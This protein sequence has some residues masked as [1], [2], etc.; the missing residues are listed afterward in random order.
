M[1]NLRT[2]LSYSFYTLLVA[3][4][5]GCQGGTSG[6]STKKANNYYSDM[7]SNKKFSNKIVVTEIDGC[8]YVV[9]RGYE[10]GGITHKANCKNPNHNCN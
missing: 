6:D 5:V 7:R 10:K 2:K 1:K 9:Y 3:F 8:E 4:L